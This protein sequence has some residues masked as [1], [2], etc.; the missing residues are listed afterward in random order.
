[1][2]DGRVKW[3]GS[4]A[5]QTRKALRCIFQV[6]RVPLPIH[7]RFRDKNQACNHLYL[8]RHARYDMNMTR[9]E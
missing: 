8:F 6:S 3:Q 7:N 1:M 9:N 4:Y 5:L 2:L